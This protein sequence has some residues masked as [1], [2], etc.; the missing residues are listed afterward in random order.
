MGLSIFGLFSC[1]T[2]TVHVSISDINDNYPQFSQSG[3]NFTI[4]E[5]ASIGTTITIL[6]GTVTDIDAGTNAEYTFSLSG[7]SEQD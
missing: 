7:T 6:T 2:A 5:S 4:S 1:S 3:Y